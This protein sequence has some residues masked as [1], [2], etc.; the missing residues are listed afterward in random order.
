[1]II[2]DCPAPGNSPKDQN[3]SSQFPLEVFVQLLIC[4]EVVAQKRRNAKTKPS[5]AIKLWNRTEEIL[6]RDS[7]Q[8]L[9]LPSLLLENSFNNGVNAQAEIAFSEVAE[10]D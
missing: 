8:K 3:D 1:M 5:E 7:A 10:L 4:A 2:T 6:Q 9:M